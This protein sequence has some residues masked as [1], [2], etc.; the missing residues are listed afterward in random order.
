M[1]GEVSITGYRTNVYRPWLLRGIRDG[2]SGKRTRQLGI[3]FCARI[4]RF[5][6]DG[7]YKAAPKSNRALEG[8]G[9]GHSTVDTEDNIT[10]E[11]ERTPAVRVLE[12][13]KDDA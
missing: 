5:G 4:E 11:E 6:G 1:S 12:E 3:P 2:M 13:G 10:S 8:V 7:W 9:W